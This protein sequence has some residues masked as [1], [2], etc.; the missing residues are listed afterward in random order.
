MNTQFP[1]L[2]NVPPP[3][4][5][6]AGGSKIQDACYIQ[7]PEK[8]RAWNL[9]TKAAEDTMTHDEHDENDDAASSAK[10]CLEDT[11]GNPAWS[12]FASLS[13][14]PPPQSG[15]I[16]ADKAADDYF[17][18]PLLPRPQDPLVWWK[19]Q[20]GLLYPSLIR[21]ARGLG[22][23]IANLRHLPWERP[24]LKVHRESAWAQLPKD[25]EEPSVKEAKPSKRHW[26]VEKAKPS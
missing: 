20:G 10:Q 23:S 24:M 5:G 9:L 19:C 22:A 13:S 3:S 11:K 6:N 8:M 25:T 12:A 14:N 18:A 16:V 4:P 17:K 7:K 2:K 21:A 26:T 1:D 15:L